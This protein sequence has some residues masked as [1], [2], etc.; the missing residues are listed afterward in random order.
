M[1]YKMALKPKCELCPCGC[2][3]PLHPGQK[4]HSDK[5][6]TLKH[7]HEHEHSHECHST[8]CGC[9][10]EEAPVSHKAACG[11]GSCGAGDAKSSHS[12]SGSG[13]CACGSCEDEDSCGSCSHCSGEEVIEKKDII[14][15]ATGAVLFAAALIIP[16]PFIYSL[17]LYLSAYLVIGGD[18]LLRA[19]RNILR[20]RVFDENF[21]MSIA[22]IGAFAIAEYPEAVAVMLFYQVGE[23]FQ[24]FAVNRSRRSITKLMDIKPEYANLKKGNTDVKVP[25]EDVSI[26]DII[27]IKPGE[28]FPLDGTVVCGSSFADTTALTG[29]SVPRSVNPGDYV[30]SG[31]IN[32]SGLIEVEVKKT[33]GESAVSK[34]LELV[35]NAS[36]RK[37][38]AE[39][40]ISRFARVYTPA[41]VISAALIAL[42]PPV[43]FGQ[44]LSDWLG[45]ALVFLVISCPCALVISIPLG[46]FGG[47]GA[48]SRK[49]VLVK[50][51]NY[52]EALKDIKTIVFDKTGTLTQGVFKVSEVSVYNGFSAED[53]LEFA[54]YAESSSTHP[55]AK[56]ILSAY[57]AKGKTVHKSEISG[58]EEIS[59]YGIKAAVGGRQ[60]LAGSSK[61]LES[62]GIAVPECVQG[63]SVYIAVDGKAAGA[64][65][66]ADSLKPDAI[67]AIADIKAAGVERIVMLT[68]DRQESAKKIAGELGIDE[69]YAELLPQ[70]KVSRLEELMCGGVKTAFVGDGINDAPVLA[71]AD[72]GI[73]M[74]GLGSDAAIEAADIVI[75][76][77]EP[78]RLAP[79]IRIA[80]KTKRIV[81]QNIALAM[82]V[83][84]IVLALGAGGIATLWEAVFADVGVA[85]LAIL[86]AMRAM[87]VIQNQRS[88]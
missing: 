27:V 68:G 23:A 44:L 31:F 41:V 29:E 88:M 3:Q 11:C 54:A 84:L 42:V 77:D 34:I 73:A 62:S 50:G 17:A 1:K 56:S 81:L 35:E 61:L 71:R 8:T 2:G 32:G 48:A 87:R 18:V 58:Y 47:I 14:R 85:L 78:S 20:G 74:G 75:M 79:A 28:R 4:H 66:I 80:R 21:L 43:L 49:G 40:F 12:H 6:H 33:F 38:R 10:H 15:L 64:I 30:Y 70:D 26:G 5:T 63:T 67:Q 9:C 36:S 69:F 86:N 45:R 60:V 59:G 53:V 57:E 72:I 7:A 76:N 24:S 13:S 19:G 55:I 39:N 46:F 82:G 52:L 83:K 25:P 51:G 37:A 22:T 16:L 65:S